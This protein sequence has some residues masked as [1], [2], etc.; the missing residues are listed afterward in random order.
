MF[1]PSKQEQSSSFKVTHLNTYLR[2]NVIPLLFI[3]WTQSPQTELESH[4][5]KLEEFARHS[6]QIYSAVSER[7]IYSRGFKIL[8]LRCNKKTKQT[9]EEQLPV[10]HTSCLVKLNMLDVFWTNTK[11]LGSIV[12]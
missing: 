10:P 8:I 11:Q 5:P 6:L 4:N 1:L 7:E 9:L 3:S 12:V 2:P